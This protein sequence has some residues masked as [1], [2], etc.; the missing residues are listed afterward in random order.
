[1]ISSDETESTFVSSVKILV[2]PEIRH[3]F[4]AYSLAFCIMSS[5][6]TTHVDHH[7]NTIQSYWFQWVL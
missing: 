7:R 2:R 5:F 3:R 4:K 1:M 6:S